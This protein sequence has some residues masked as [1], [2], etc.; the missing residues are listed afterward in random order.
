MA[1]PSPVAV[2][3]AAYAI[4]DC[5]VASNC[6]PAVKARRWLRGAEDYRRIAHAALMAALP[7][8]DQQDRP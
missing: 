8:L 5:T 1:Y 4:F 6:S 7:H 2:M 3:A